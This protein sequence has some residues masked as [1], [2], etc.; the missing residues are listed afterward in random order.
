MFNNGMPI[1]YPQMFM[2]SMQ[3]PMM[4]QPNQ[5][6]SQFNQIGGITWVQGETGA[7]S[8]I[9]PTPN[10]PY[11]LWDSESQTIYLKSID[12]SGLPSIKILD[13]TI[14]EQTPTKNAVISETTSEYV[15]KK[16]FEDFKAEM[17][18]EYGA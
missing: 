3:S 17:K 1:G 14:R 6:S 13:Y 9:V 11:P 16:E 18:E 15:T 7:K 10:I 5:A 12:T 8:F 2:P 4:V